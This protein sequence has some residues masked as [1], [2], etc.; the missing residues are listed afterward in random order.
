M[1]E[2]E[3][4]LVIKKSDILNEVARTTSY[5]GA[6]LISDKDPNAYERIFTT[7]EDREALE[8]FWVESKNAACEALKRVIVSE[9]EKD[10]TKNGKTEKEYEITLALSSRFDEALFESMQRD[11]VSYFV[12]NIVAKWYMYTNK[13]EAPAYAAEA[14][15]HLD[16]ARRKALYKTSPDRPVTVAMLNL[17]IKEY[18][19]KIKA[20]EL[21]AKKDHNHDSDYAKIGS[22]TPHVIISGADYAALAAKDPN[23]L[24]I[25]S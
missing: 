8:R 10:I 5:T 19:T 13:A 9:L 2:L 25:I 6:N 12:N 7:D 1:I 15:A 3:H 17:F 11:M 16:A 18:I 14:V 24:Y 21:Y 23:T 4:T 22:V 20:D